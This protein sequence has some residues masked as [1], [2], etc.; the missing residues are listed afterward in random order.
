MNESDESDEEEV[1]TQNSQY[2]K[3]YIFL[4]DRSGSMGGSTIVMAR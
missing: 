3:E 4:I 1:N 2:V